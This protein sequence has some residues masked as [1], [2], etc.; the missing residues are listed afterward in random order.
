MFKFTSIFKKNMTVKLPYNTKISTGDEM[1]KTSL[2]HGHE[3]TEIAYLSAGQKIIENFVSLI[4]VH[5][6]SLMKE[7]TS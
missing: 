6:P 2:Q 5:R 4:K 7:V 1:F 3:N